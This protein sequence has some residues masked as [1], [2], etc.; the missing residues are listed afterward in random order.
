M[1]LN[2]YS[3]EDPTSVESLS[4]TQNG[5]YNAPTGKAYSP[6]VVSV[7]GG[8]TPITPDYSGILYF[9]DYDGTVLHTYN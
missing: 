2:Y 1:I 5:T 7:E 8:D 9:I 4:V 6:V 3:M